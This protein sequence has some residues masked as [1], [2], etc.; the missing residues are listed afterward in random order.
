MVRLYTLCGLPFAGKTT[1]AKA[2]EHRFGIARIDEDLVQDAIHFKPPA[3]E[4][5]VLRYHLS[6]PLDEWIQQTF[7]QN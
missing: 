4:E 6:Q 7:L 5:Q 3:Q 1:I 2:L